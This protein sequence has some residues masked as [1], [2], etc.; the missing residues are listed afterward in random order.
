M[1]G[2]YQ[3]RFNG[4]VWVSAGPADPDSGL[5]APARFEGR[6]QSSGTSFQPRA[7]RMFP[8]K[9]RQPVGNV[10]HASLDFVHP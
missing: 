4:F 5:V 6:G 7:A 2:P 10:D 8:D 9:N 3:Q 1:R